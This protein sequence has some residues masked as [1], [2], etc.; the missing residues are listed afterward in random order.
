MKVILTERGLE[1]LSELQETINNQ[2]TAKN[3]VLSVK[4]QDNRSRVPLM[5]IHHTERNSM[6]SM[7]SMGR[8][9]QIPYH[10]LD[11]STA[12]PSEVVVKAPKLKISAYFKEKY[13]NRGTRTA[14]MSTP[15]HQQLMGGTLSP[16]QTSP[17]VFAEQSSTFRPWGQTSLSPNQ[18][19]APPIQFPSPRAEEMGGMGGWKWG[20]GAG[21]MGSQPMGSQSIQSMQSTQ[22]M[23]SLRSTPPPPD[24]ISAPSPISAASPTHIRGLLADAKH[25]E[26][27]KS[28]RDL[29][30]VRKVGI[31]SDPRPFSY[32]KHS[33][34]RLPITP[35]KKFSPL[36][37]MTIPKS[38]PSEPIIPTF[39][40]IA[41][42]KFR[43]STADLTHRVRSPLIKTQSAASNT[44]E[45]KIREDLKLKKIIARHNSIENTRSNIYNHLQKKM[46]KQAI[47]HDK[48]L[49]KIAH[50]IVDEKPR[51]SYLFRKTHDE[52]RKQD[53][54][55]KQHS[56]YMQIWKR[57]KRSTNLS[58]NMRGM[59][60]KFANRESE[61]ENAFHMRI[62]SQMANKYN[63]VQFP[64]V[65]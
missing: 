41:M 1:Y 55:L 21:G 64:V 61:R 54:M 56:R 31:Y 10:P 35:I 65:H 12:P 19:S 52:D 59:K 7:N 6:N 60:I 40:A 23:Q 13:I 20:E 28:A 51:L 57:E 34:A 45:Y 37:T 24:S 27:S 42:Q 22:P 30:G 29:L 38:T 49:E 3:R 44:H 39:H 9:E 15:R 18:V 58:T 32:R 36:V 63:V 14:G 53:R 2:S 4:Y 26:G 62:N 33:M 25:W 47:E 5:K 11:L 48:E 43:L 8:T 16:P 46:T 50:Q 17:A